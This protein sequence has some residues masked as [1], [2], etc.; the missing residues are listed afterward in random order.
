M[1]KE[2]SAHSP[3]N[4]TLTITVKNY[5][6]A[7][8]W[9]LSL[10]RQGHYQL[11]KNLIDVKKKTENKRRKNLKPRLDTILMSVSTQK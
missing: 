4:K 6:K 9:N 11:S 1:K 10:H 8:L 2:L 3:W 7:D 5:T